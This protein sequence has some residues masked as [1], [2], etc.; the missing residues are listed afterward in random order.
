MAA[1]ETLLSMD[2]RFNTPPSINAA[3]FYTRN[4]RPV[5]RFHPDNAQS[6]LFPAIM[7][8]SYTGNGV[9]VIIYWVSDATAGNVVWAA[10]FESCSPGGHDLDSDDFAQEQTAVG[11]APS[12]SGVMTYTTISFSDGVQMDSVSSGVPF[13]LKVTR[14]ASDSLDT[15][16]GYAQL[17]FIEVREKTS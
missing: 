10:A 5:I 13:R 16:T 1:G 12:T 11:S 3:T 8:R 17:L 2:A 4:A 7:P 15:C 14:R 6:A 9:D